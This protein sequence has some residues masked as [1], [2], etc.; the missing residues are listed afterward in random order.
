MYFIIFISIDML[1]ILIFLVDV[2]INKQKWWYFVEKYVGY[3]DGFYNILK[4]HRGE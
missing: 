2:I 4:E 1:F 3:V